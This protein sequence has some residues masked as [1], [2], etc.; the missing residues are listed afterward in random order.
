MNMKDIQK[1]QINVYE[2]K[3]YRSIIFPCRRDTLGDDDDCFLRMIMRQM[4][5]RKRIFPY[6]KYLFPKNKTESQYFHTFTYTKKRECYGLHLIEI[7]KPKNKRLKILFIESGDNA[8]KNKIIKGHYIVIC[9]MKDKIAEFVDLR[10]HKK[11]FL[12]PNV[13]TSK[14]EKKIDKISIKM[15]LYHCKR[16]KMMNMCMNDNRNIMINEKIKKFGKLYKMKYGHTWY[17]TFGFRKIIYYSNIVINM[18][19]IRTI[20]KSF[21]KTKKLDKYLYSMLNEYEKFNYTQN[22]YEN[23]NFQNNNNNKTLNS[24]SINKH[25]IKYKDVYIG[26]FIDK[27][28]K[29]LNIEIGTDSKLKNSV[30]I[31]TDTRIAIIKSVGKRNKTNLHFDSKKI[32]NMGIK[33]C[34]KLHVKNI[35]LV[36]TAKF[37]CSNKKLSLSFLYFIKYGEPWYSYNFGFVLSNKKDRDNYIKSKKILENL[38]VVDVIS[39]IPEFEDYVT[40]NITEINETLKFVDFFNKHLKTGRLS[41]LHCYYLHHKDLFHKLIETFG[42]INFEGKLFVLQ[43]K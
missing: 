18:N 4:F 21:D 40:I 19:R 27:N 7:N 9:D 13:E 14:E 10:L 11:W 2:Y 30:L 24:I 34:K 38:T 41:K 28:D 15:L 5:F 33:I 12:N 17:E 32:I 16:L 26:Y 43:L 8:I 35:E 39:K 22:N 42:L 6:I 25:I 23:N 31:Q 20:K 1:K 3:M 37:E 36:D 29:S